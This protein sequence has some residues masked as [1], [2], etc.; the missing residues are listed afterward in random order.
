MDIRIEKRNREK[1]NRANDENRDNL[2][3]RGPTSDYQPRLSDVPRRVN[4]VSSVADR[5][6]GVDFRRAA[7]REFPAATRE[8]TALFFIRPS[9]T[10]F[11]EIASRSLEIIFETADIGKLIRSDL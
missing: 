3:R 10:A 6:N 9:F 7:S 4:T 11:T 5:L 1:E 2:F 8:N